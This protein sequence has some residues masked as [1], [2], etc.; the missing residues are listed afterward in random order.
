MISPLATLSG[1][2]LLL[3]LAA[4]AALTDGLAAYYDFENNLQDRSGNGRHLTVVS[5]NPE[6]AWAGGI[7]TR[8][9]SS[10]DRSTLLSGKA[11]NL[12]DADG[13]VLKAPLGSGPAAVTAGS[14]NLGGSFTLSAWHFLAPLPDNTS[15][16]YF[17]FEAADTGNYDVSWGTSSGDTY[18]A[19]NSSIAGPSIQQTRGSWHH[20]VHVFQTV[21]ETLYLTVYA[22]GALIG[23]ISAPIADMNFSQLMIGNARTGQDRKWDG[24][25]DEVAIWNRALTPLEVDELEARGRGG[26][27]VAEDLASHGKAYIGMASNQ[28]ALGTVSGS[29]LYD[30]GAL[31]VISAQATTPGYRFLAWDG[32]FTGQP[33][34]FEFVVTS[35]TTA[36]A[37]FGADMRDNDNDG[38]TNFDEVAVHGTNPDLADTDADGI[39]DRDEVELTGTSPVRSDTGLIG[40]AN[41]TFGPGNTGGIALRNPR[42]DLDPVTGDIFLTLGFLGS[43]DLLDWTPLEA[44]GN[45]AILPSG[46]L[47]IRFP[48]PSDQV[49]T[50]QLSGGRP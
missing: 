27:G 36:S 23:K 2:V 47:R 35:S 12:V 48:A 46:G 8:G 21:G 26:F 31:A 16:R 29:G 43:A 9:A 6:P 18:Q 45:A 1:F 4:S 24:L 30:V 14:Y 44:T 28:P 10:I 50:Y 22:D 33:D 15:P 7:V 41:E 39:S 49:S 13:D 17:V 34:A 32:S 5:G 37:S 19:Y 38:L 42:I 3:P 11:L 25:L 40:L 20:T